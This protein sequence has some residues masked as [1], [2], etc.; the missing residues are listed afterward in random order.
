M[1]DC[2]DA[3]AKVIHSGNRIMV[4]EGTIVNQN[5]E[6]VAKGIGTFNAYPVEKAG[7]F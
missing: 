2:L 3:H 6:L 7:L 4:C 1:G 5:G